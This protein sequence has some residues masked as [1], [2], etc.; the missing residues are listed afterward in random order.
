MAAGRAAAKAGVPVANDEAQAAWLEVAKRVANGDRENLSCPV[1]HDGYLVVR[2]IPFQVG[3]GGEY[4]MRCPECGAENFL[5]VR[6]TGP[7]QE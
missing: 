6:D 2:W 5:L 3:G 4:Q 7:G 1:R